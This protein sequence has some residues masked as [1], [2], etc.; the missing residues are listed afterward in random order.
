MCDL[1]GQPPCQEKLAEEDEN[2]HKLRLLAK[3]TVDKEVTEAP[4]T[5]PNYVIVRKATGDKI[6]DAET[7]TNVLKTHQRAE[8]R[9]L[10]NLLLTRPGK[11]RKVIID[12]SNWKDD[13][14]VV[15]DP[16]V[17]D[18]PDEEN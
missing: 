18:D 1:R 16:E 11:R 2:M 4:R 7:A 9:P 5:K 14:L 12:S 13:E 3:I 6:I 17:K 8:A 10:Q 15:T